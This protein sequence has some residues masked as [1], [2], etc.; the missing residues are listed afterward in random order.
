MQPDGYKL[1]GDGREQDIIK[2]LQSEIRKLE[3]QLERL[4]V[5][6][7]P[8]KFS[9]MKTYQTMIASREEL[10]QQMQPRL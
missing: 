8:H 4:Q 9:L 3:S 6:D 10:L 7:T 2:R 1:R 5:E